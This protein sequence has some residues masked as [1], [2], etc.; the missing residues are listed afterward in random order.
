MSA[1]ATASAHPGKTV[2]V[3]CPDSVTENAPVTFS[4]NVSGGSGN[5]TPTYNWTVSAGRIISGQG[6]TSITVDT[7]GLAGQTIRATLDVEGYGVPCPAS[8]SVSLPIDLKPR[9]FDEYYDIARTRKARLDNFAISCRRA[10]SQ[11]YIIVIHHRGEIKRRKARDQISDYMVT[12]AASTPP[13]TVTWDGSEKTG[14]RIV[15]LSARSPPPGPAIDFFLRGDLTAR[16]PF[17]G[18]RAIFFVKTELDDSP[19]SRFEVN[20]SDRFAAP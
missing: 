1:R 11:G 9:K 12:R 3:T 17:L 10:G 19:F 16:F 8:C 20:L 6:T 18:N 7:A 2:S 14:D 15:Y 13:L 5:V 4:A